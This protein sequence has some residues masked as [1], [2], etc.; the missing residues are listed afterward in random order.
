MMMIKAVFRKERDGGCCCNS[1][2][3]R[4]GGSYHAMMMIKAVFSKE[5]DGGM[6]VLQFRGR[7]ERGTVLPTLVSKSISS[8]CHLA[9]SLQHSC[10]LGTFDSLVFLDSPH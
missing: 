10:A 8:C 2:V 9:P 7:E 1:E 3:G 4:E 6:M 5:S